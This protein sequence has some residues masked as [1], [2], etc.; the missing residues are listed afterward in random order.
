MIDITK[1]TGSILCFF[2]KMEDDFA[3]INLRKIGYKSH[4]YI[5][6]LY[7][8]KTQ[9]FENIFENNFYMRFMIRDR[10]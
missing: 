7:L 5:Y 10:K 1:R 4:I 2:F 8:F 6:I 3:M 9:D